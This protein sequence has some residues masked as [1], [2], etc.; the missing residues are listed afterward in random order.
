MV[1]Q[2][3]MII[4]KENSTLSTW[5]KAFQVLKFHLMRPLFYPTMMTY[6][7]APY[8]GDPWM[9]KAQSTGHSSQ[10]RGG[11]ACPEIVTT[12]QELV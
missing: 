6:V 4:K 11:Q 7:G 5:P 1:H 3:L 9:H 12:V 2:N 8:T 10:T